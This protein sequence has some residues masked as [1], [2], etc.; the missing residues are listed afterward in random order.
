M[1]PPQVSTGFSDPS[2]ID[3]F[4]CV[5]LQEKIEKIREEFP[6][7]QTLA[8]T[9]EKISNAKRSLRFSEFEP[10][11]TSLDLKTAEEY[12]LS[13]GFKIK[14]WK[15]INRR[16]PVFLEYETKSESDECLRD[17]DIFSRKFDSFKNQDFSELCLVLDPTKFLKTK[18]YNPAENKVMFR[19]MTLF[20]AVVTELYPKLQGPVFIEKVTFL[21]EKWGEASFHL[22]D[23][24][25]FY[26]EFG[27]GLQIWTQVPKP[28]RHYEIKK[29]WDTMYKKKL[30]LRMTNFDIDERFPLTS[31]VEY[32]Y[33]EKAI[34][35][36]SCP[37]QNCFYGTHRRDYYEAHISKCR[38]TTRVTYAQKRFQKPGNEVREQLAA[39][40]ILPDANFQNMMFC[41]FDIGKN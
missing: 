22:N 41:T 10:Y 39:E 19:K 40:G 13:R 8:H 9:R 31:T 29:I 28:N 12:A 3:F 37:N 26:D 27:L 14:I 25:R 20:Q 30:R 7:D 17:L 2:Q 36:F 32:I 16:K 24:K 5:L 11:R 15:Q 34:N 18:K 6:D 4:K 21:E 35:Y 1:A 38:T 33:D 23:S